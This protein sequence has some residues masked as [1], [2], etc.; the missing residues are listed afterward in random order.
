MLAPHAWPGLRRIVRVESATL[1]TAVRS[2][3]GIENS[4][5]WVLDVQFG[6]DH[7]RMRSRRGV[8]NMALLRHL[9]LNLL[10]QDG[11]TEGSV[12]GKR[13]RAAWQPDSIGYPVDGHRAARPRQTFPQVGPHRDCVDLVRHSRSAVDQ[14]PT[15]CRA[16]RSRAGSRAPRTRR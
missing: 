9:T 13:E 5:H 8:E 6:E 14:T 16:S 1:L 10:A 4:L 11:D 2:H 12:K 7:S 15:R 3:W